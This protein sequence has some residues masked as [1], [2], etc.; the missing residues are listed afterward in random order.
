MKPS[1]KGLVRKCDMAF[2]QYI[3]ER[4]NYVC[5]TCGRIGSKRDGVMQ[6]GHLMTRSAYSTRWTEENAFCQCAACNLR[7]EY[8]PNPFI[9]RFIACKG[10]DAYNELYKQHKAPHKFTN[11]DLEVIAMTY[12]T[13]AEGYD[14]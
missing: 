2:S 7:H 11:G 12:K 3:R 6:C 14:C 9:L 8:D 1:R 5:F 13:R 10:Y 4:D